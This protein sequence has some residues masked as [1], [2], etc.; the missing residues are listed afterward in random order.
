MGMDA[1]QLRYRHDFNKATSMTRLLCLST[2]W[3]ILAWSV[4]SFAADDVETT[5]VVAKDLTLSVPKVWKQQQPS[6]AMRLAQFGV[7]P[8]ERDT[9]AA[10]L[11][12]SGPFGGSVADN[13]GRWLGQFQADGRKVTMTQGEAPQGKYVLVDVAGTFNRPDGPP[14]RQKTVAT[15]GYRAVNVMIIIPDKGSYFLKLTGP[16]KTVGTAI[17]ALRAS[18]GGDQSKESPFEL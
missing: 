1:V 6:N 2:C 4:C 7:D 13:V 11:V 16:E 9:A 10:E 8:A 17:E 15:P 12:V 18:F 3:T 14:I 5:S